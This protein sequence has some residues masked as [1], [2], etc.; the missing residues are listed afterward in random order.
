M[1]NS[2]K[3]EFFNKNKILIS[4][5]VYILASLSLCLT[6]SL[7][8]LKKNPL[9]VNENFNINILNLQFDNGKLIYN[10][11]NEGSFYQVIDGINYYLIKLPIFPLLM[12]GILS[13]FNNYFFVFSFKAFIS[14]T[15]FFVTI[16]IYYKDNNLNFRTYIFLLISTLIIP[17]NIHVYFQIH[18][19][20]S[21]GSILI[22]SLFL[23]CVSQKKRFI[24]IGILLAFL[25]LTKS[26]YFFLCL[27]LPIYFFIK[28]KTLKSLTVLAFLLVAVMS[29]GFFG[30]KKSKIFPFFSTLSSHGQYQFAAVA[31]QEFKNLYPLYSVDLYQIP[32]LTKS[33]QTEKE[34]YYFYK[35]LNIQYLSEYK[36][37]LRYLQ[38]RFIVLKFIFFD[39]IKDGNFNIND[40]NIKIRF[41]S[42]LNKIFFNISFIISI[43]F[44]FRKK[45]TKGNEINILLFSFL[46]LNLLPHLVSWAT[47]KHLIGI[48][49][50]SLFYLIILKHYLKRNFSNL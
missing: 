6:Y 23:L 31:N 40:K 41:S 37:K 15:I 18:F 38:D 8:Y 11:I 39:I 45:F 21:L 2:E 9:I 5:F 14:F 17:Y 42:I 4:Y 50:I 25:Y 19:S 13:L 36:N 30:L 16:Y 26:S 10:I 49:Q 32:N 7:I 1:K 28:F 46:S 22:S 29:W 27:F 3:L 47:S 44:I 24:L 12:S 35:K 43:Y 48:S 33:I 34:A 20:D